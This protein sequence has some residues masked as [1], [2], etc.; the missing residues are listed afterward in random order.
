MNRFF[1]TKVQDIPKPMNARKMGCGP[2]PF[3]YFNS[4]GRLP[5]TSLLLIPPLLLLL[6]A[7]GFF[8]W[9][10]PIRAMLHCHVC[11]NAP[12]YHH[13]SLLQAV[14]PKAYPTPSLPVIQPVSFMIYTPLVIY[15]SGAHKGAGGMSQFTR[16][17]VADQ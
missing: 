6:I 14:T 4:T 13:P 12:P 10:K 1:V 7:G 8:K 17:Y 15:A 9:G 5:V 3:N 2:F 11:Q 16:R